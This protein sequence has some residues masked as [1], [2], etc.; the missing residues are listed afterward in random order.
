MK[1]EILSPAGSM[2][3]AIASILNGANAIYMGTNNFNARRNAKNLTNDEIIDCVKFAHIRGVKVYVVLNTLINDR[4]FGLLE[5]EVKFI[6][7]IGVDAVI[8]QDLGVIEFIRQIA[9]KLPIHASTQLLIHNLDGALFAKDL[10]LERVVLSRELTLGAI[11]YITKNAEIQTEVFV[12]GALCM[13]YSGGCYISSIIGQRS[14]NRGLCA[15][16]CRLPFSRDIGKKGEHLLSLKDLSLID[17]ILKLRDIGVS[18]LKIEGRMKRAEYAGAVTDIYSRVLNENRLATADEKLLLEK[19]FSRTGF[20]DGYATGDKG[21]HMFGVKTEYTDADEIYKKYQ[22]IKETPSIALNAQFIATDKITFKISDDLGNEVSYVSTDIGQALKQATQKEQIGES[23]SK[24]G[25]TPFYIKNLDIDIKDGIY[26]SKATLN[27]IRRSAIDLLIELREKVAYREFL[28]YVPDKKIINKKFEGFTVSVLKFNQITDFILANACQ[29]YIPLSEIIANIN[30]IKNIEKIICIIPK[31]YNDK[32]ADEI[33]KALDR[34]K[35]IGI[36]KIL[37]TN[38]A[39]I[40]IAKKYNFIMIGD[41]SLNIFNSLALRSVKNMGIIRQT[42]SFELML[43]QI[44]DINKYID[45]EIFV[46]GYLPLMI[47]ENCRIK[48]KKCVC[49]IKQSYLYDRNKQAF[50]LIPEFGCRNTLLNCKKLYLKDDYNNIGIKYA[51]LS[52]TIE[53]REECENIFR[54]FIKGEVIEDNIT[55]GLYYRGVK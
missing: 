42:L 6:N 1:T 55:N 11:E 25:G 43:S 49:E 48:D 20:T 12:H 24:T 14:G 21:E 5:E 37:C 26:I 36:D 28:P 4:E 53:E 45:T 50:P 8:V 27:L 40:N 54:A 3:G 35:A 32:E 52:F 19:V 16:P 38:V 31:I 30:D 13:S 10:G 9:P 15:Q 39:S 47:F 23:L 22:N 2:D 41:Y 7:N 17:Y 46:Y 44:R 18:S 33:Y 51:R 29:I 34:I